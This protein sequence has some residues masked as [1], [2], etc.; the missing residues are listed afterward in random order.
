MVFSSYFFKN[1]FS[2]ACPFSS[3]SND[4]INTSSQFG[5][6]KIFFFK[7]NYKIFFIVILESEQ[8]Q[9]YC[10]YLNYGDSSENQGYSSNLWISDYVPDIPVWSHLLPIDEFLSNYSEQNLQNLTPNEISMAEIRNL[11][12]LRLAVLWKAYIANS[13]GTVAT[14]FG[15]NL[16]NNPFSD[17][18]SYKGIC[19]IPGNTSLDVAFI[20]T[21][22]ELEELQ[23]NNLIKITSPHLAKNRNFSTSN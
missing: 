5:S 20:L 19:R 23:N 16:I 4:V 1:F 13:D 6:R 3:F 8:T 11:A 2:R 9:N 14:V 12:H 7:F 21:E 17:F 18:Q 10:F 22:E 15:E